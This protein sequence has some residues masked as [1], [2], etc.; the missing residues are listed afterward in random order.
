MRILF[1]AA[2]PME[3][4]G[5]LAHLRGQEDVVMGTVWAR[6]G[7]LGEHKVLLVSNGAGRR[8]AAAAADA[9]W[10][11]LSP[12]VVVSTGFCGALDESL[13]VADIVSASKVNTH[14]AILL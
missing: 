8:R 10:K 1:V 7:R 2:E 9:G 13:H 3:Y 4:K 5:I 14:S 6:S 11:H 12:D